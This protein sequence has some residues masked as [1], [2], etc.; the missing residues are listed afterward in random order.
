MAK[1]VADKHVKKLVRHTS[2]PGPG[3]TR[4][5]SLKQRMLP[6]LIISMRN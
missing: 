3:P 1:D 5:T 6:D 2:T 4:S